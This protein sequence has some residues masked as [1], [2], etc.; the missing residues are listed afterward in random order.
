M[1]CAISSLLL[2]I[3]KYKKEERVKAIPFD[4]L[5]FFFYE[6]ELSDN[7]LTNSLQMRLSRIISTSSK[8]F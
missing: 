7:I 6:Q 8:R 1:K 3:P 5:A 4:E 2:F